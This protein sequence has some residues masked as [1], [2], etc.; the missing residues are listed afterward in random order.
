M[1]KKQCREKNLFA[2]QILE[3]FDHAGGDLAAMRKKR[4]PDA[5]KEPELILDGN[6]MLNA[7]KLIQELK[8]LI[9]KRRLHKIIQSMNN[10]DQTEELLTRLEKEC[11]FDDHNTPIQD[12]TNCLGSRYGGWLH[13]LE[14]W[15]YIIDL[16]KGD[17]NHAAH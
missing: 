10:T 7:A 16:G 5:I 8:T 6:S 1:A 12:L 2:Y 11:G 4:L 14:L 3:S 9:P 13:L 17:N 15:D